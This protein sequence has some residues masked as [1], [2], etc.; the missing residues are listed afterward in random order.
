MQEQSKSAVREKACSSSKELQ[1]ELASCRDA[2]HGDPTGQA[3]CFHSPHL[4]VPSYTSCFSVFSCICLFVFISLCQSFRSTDAECRNSPAPSS[5]SPNAHN[6]FVFAIDSVSWPNQ[7]QLTLYHV[8]PHILGT[9]FKET[10]FDC[11]FFHICWYGA[12]KPTKGSK[13][14]S[15]ELWKIRKCCLGKRGNR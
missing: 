6:C 7:N 13:R 3:A 14:L 8:I 1:R 5:A 12:Q 10:D 11:L 4:P 15:P 9:L 2:H